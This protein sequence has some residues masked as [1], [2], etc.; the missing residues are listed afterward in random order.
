MAYENIS[1]FDAKELVP[2]TYD[3]GIEEAPQA[4]ESRSNFESNITVVPQDFPRLRNIPTIDNNAT[5]IQQRRSVAENRNVQTK[6]SYREVAKSTPKKRLMSESGFR[7]FE[8]TSQEINTSPSTSKQSN[9]KPRSIYSFLSQPHTPITRQGTILSKPFSTSQTYNQPN[10]SASYNRSNDD[11]VKEF[12]TNFMQFP[13]DFRLKLR[14]LINTSYHLSKLP[15]D[16]D[17]VGSNLT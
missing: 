1:Y 6:R 5:S 3:A 13:E 8:S 12:Y 14:E 4:H 15:P 17:S 10:N 11:R 9:D 16:I 2:K 7:G